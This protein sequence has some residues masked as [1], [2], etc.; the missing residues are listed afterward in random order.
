MYSHIVGSS[1]TTVSAALRAASRWSPE[2][3][4]HDVP[5]G[6]QSAFAAGGRA[7]TVCLGAST[8][9]LDTLV[10][11]CEASGCALAVSGYVS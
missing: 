1:V 5:P 2:S 8:P 7:V 10:A 4:T 6:P 11:L 3:H 9:A